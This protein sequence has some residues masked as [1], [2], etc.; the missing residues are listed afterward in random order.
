MKRSF[1]FICCNLVCLLSIA[2]QDTFKFSCINNQ[3]EW[4]KVYDKELTFEELTLFVKTNGHFENIEVLDECIIATIKN[5]EAEYKT[6]GYSELS[7]PMYVSRSFY[8]GKVVINWKPEKYRVTVK[9]IMLTQKYDDGLSKEGEM[10][11]LDSFAVKKGKNLIKNSFLKK[12]GEII[13][14]TFSALF[15]ISDNE[16]NDNW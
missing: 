16:N 10:S 8:S 2:Q 3:L 7:V 4:Q 12:P 15:L 1:L 13:N 6:L 5:I 14:H 9:N 11:S